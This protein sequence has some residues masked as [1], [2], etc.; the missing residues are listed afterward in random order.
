MKPLS[1]FLTEFPNY[2]SSY[3]PVFLYRRNKN[4]KHIVSN[5]KVFDGTYLS[6][7][8]HLQIIDSQN[9][10][11]ISVINIYNVNLLF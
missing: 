10:E 2:L 5:V 6:T 1:R 3:L 9:W 7:F 8:I 11:V 4:P